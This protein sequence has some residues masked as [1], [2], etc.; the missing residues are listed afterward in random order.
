MRL[1]LVGLPLWALCSRVL[2]GAASSTWQC[3]PHLPEAIGELS[4]LLFPVGM[5]LAARSTRMRPGAVGGG[6]RGASVRAG[7][8]APGVVPPVVL[9]GGGVPVE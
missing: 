8:A 5:R 6:W 7:I 2:S 9:L 4:P 3:A 1:D